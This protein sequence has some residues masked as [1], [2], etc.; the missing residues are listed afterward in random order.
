[1]TS[2]NSSIANPD[3]MASLAG[4]CLDIVRARLGESQEPIRL[5]QDLDTHALIGFAGKHGAATALAGGIR[6]AGV[7]GPY[8]AGLQMMLATIE[9]SNAA[10]NRAMRQTLHD[11]GQKLGDAGISCVAL[12]GGAF[13][14]QDPASAGWRTAS[15]LDLLVSTD[16]LKEAI[17]RLQDAGYRKTGSEELYRQED[18]Q[19]FP[20]LVSPG[21][22]VAVELHTRTIWDPG[23][24]PLDTADVL[25]QASPGP[26]PYRHSGPVSGAPHH[27]PRRPLPDQ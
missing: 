12:K 24:D 15:D 20:A 1:M 8:A 14:A 9:R 3:H 21:G 16:Q 11:I 13:I 26:R 27:P 4:L 19:H 7:E 6:K 10:K 18:H 23:R 2:Q 22:D 25:A 5:P 17:T